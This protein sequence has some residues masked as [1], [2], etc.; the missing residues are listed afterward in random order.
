MG[1]W[2]FLID[3]NLEPQ[4]AVSLE[5]RGIAAEH[6]RD[7]LRRGATDSEVL[8]YARSQDALVVT[9]DKKDFA[10]ISYGDHEGILVLRDERVSAYETARA[11]GNLVDAYPDRDSLRHREPLDDWL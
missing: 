1:D 7:A 5:K 6:V 8:Q 2:H 10:R 9:L 4:I 3:E 11:I